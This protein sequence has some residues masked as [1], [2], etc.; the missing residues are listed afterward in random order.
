MPTASAVPDQLLLLTVLNVARLPSPRLVRAV[1]ATTSERLFAVCKKDPVLCTAAVPSPRLVRAPEAVVAPVPPF[2]MATVPETFVA[3]PESVAVIVPAVKLPDASRFTIV[4]A[5]LRFVAALASVA[6]VLKVFQLAP[7][8]R[9]S[10][11]PAKCA[12]SMSGILNACV[13]GVV[14]STEIPVPTESVASVMICAGV[15]S[16]L[17]D[18]IVPLPPPAV[19]SVHTALPAVT[20]VATKSV[21]LVELNHMLPIE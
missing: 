7:E 8:R 19:I 12:A 9:P 3:V 5:V 2:A 6:P 14:S 18:A 16:A 1:E 4:E 13:P 21:E 15:A 10:V 17:I 11:T 20:S